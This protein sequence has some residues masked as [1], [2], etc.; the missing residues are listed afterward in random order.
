MTDL[1]ELSADGG[2]P[3]VAL[4]AALHAACF[5][6]A[7]DED[8]VTSLLAVPGTLALVA[9]AGPTQSAPEGFALLRMGPETAEILALAIT[10]AVVASRLHRPSL[11]NAAKVGRCP[12]SHH[13]S[14][15]SASA[16]S[17]PISRTRG[18]SPRFPVAIVAS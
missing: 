9:A 8:A 17:R 15:R 3:A 13:A 18:V 11:L 2:A 12:S 16:L 7:W 5:E 1:H 6:R 10:S 4:L 14:I